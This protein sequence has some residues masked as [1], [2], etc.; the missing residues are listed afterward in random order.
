MAKSADTMHIKSGRGSRVRIIRALGDI[1]I[2]PAKVPVSSR[3]CGSGAVRGRNVK[4]PV[5]PMSEMGAEMEALCAFKST[6]PDI[7]TNRFQYGR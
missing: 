4:H 2:S 7:K 1:P 6:V 5:D 3:R